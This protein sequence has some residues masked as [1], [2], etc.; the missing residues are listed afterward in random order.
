MGVYLLDA[1][2][3][4][5]IRFYHVSTLVKS[6]LLFVLAS[7]GEHSSEITDTWVVLRCRDQSYHPIRLINV[8]SYL[9]PDA[10]TPLHY[11]IYS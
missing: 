10:L 9:L 2:Y 8:V 6:C 3:G 11:I 4:M 1:Y 7:N 5:K